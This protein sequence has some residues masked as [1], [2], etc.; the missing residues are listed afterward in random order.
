MINGEWHVIFSHSTMEFL[1]HEVSDHYPA[2]IQLDQDWVS[3]P[4]L[5]K[6]FNFWTKH[7]EFQLTIGRSWKK[8]VIGAFMVLLHKKLKRLKQSLKSFNKAHFAYVS[9][10]VKNKREELVGV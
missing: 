9:I 7:S 1:H 8:H 5:F 10:K 3:L 4:K 6:F 2:F